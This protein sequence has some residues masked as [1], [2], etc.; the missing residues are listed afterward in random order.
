MFNRFFPQ[1]ELPATV[2]NAAIQIQLETQTPIPVVVSALL[3]VMS[4]A[5]QGRIRIRKRHNLVSPCSLWFIVVQES[6][7]RKSTLLNAVLRAVLRFQDEQLEGHRQLMIEYED[8]LKVWTSEQKGIL[9][10]IRRRASRGEDNGELKEQLKT[11]TSR[12]PKRP[13]RFKLV[14]EKITPEALIDTLHQ[15]YPTTS[16]MAD[17]GAFVTKGRS[18]SDMGLLNKLWDSSPI[19]VDNTDFSVVIKDAHL[20]MAL[21]IQSGVLDDYLKGKGALARAVG[22]L[23]RAFFIWPASMVGYRCIENQM[24][25]NDEA[26]KIFDERLTALLKE[27]SP[28]E[29]GELPASIELSFDWEAQKRW[30]Q[31]HDQ[32]E[33]EML[34]G[35]LQQ[36]RDFGS[37]LADNVARLA[38]IFHHFEGLEGPISLD[39]LERA[40]RLGMWYGDEFARNF[41]PPPEQP[42]EVQDAQ[43][44]EYWLADQVQIYQSHRFQKNY[45]LQCGPLRTVKRLNPAISVLWNM[46]KVQE[47]KEGRTT[48]LDLNPNFFPLGS[49]QHAGIQTDWLAANIV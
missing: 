30:D 3:A 43:A 18:L 34:N 14:L 2:L 46:Q 12:K 4:L 19:S 10:A 21:F 38:A 20:T 26:K 47:L 31:F 42:K 45:V 27:H 37:K 33:G 40:I 22:L 13:K 32:T 41:T 15:E 23:A 11:H 16:I 5:C 28:N 9:S 48:V 25:I 7:E 36:V 1:H 29:D 24:P 17:E 44:L 39:T 6:G 49:V 8:E 35:R